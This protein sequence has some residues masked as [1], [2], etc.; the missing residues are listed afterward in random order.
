MNSGLPTQC[1]IRSV[2]RGDAGVSRLDDEAARARL[3]EAV[4][5]DL[6]NPADA[7]VALVTAATGLAVPN[8][9]D[10][11]EI[12]TSSRLSVTVPPGGAVLTMSMPMM[13][14]GN[15]GV[16]PA[17]LGIVLAPDRLVT[18]RFAPSRAFLTGLG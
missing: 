6:V 3:G 18:I 9:A 16:M 17:P 11:M 1:M 15:D 5:I 12:E 13:Y 7:D 14:S 4:W 8:E 2:V 10:L